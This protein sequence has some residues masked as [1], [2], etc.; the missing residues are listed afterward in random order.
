MTDGRLSWIW[1]SLLASLCGTLAHGA[2]M[3]LKRRAGWLPGFDPAAALQAAMLDLLPPAIPSGLA[4]WLVSQLNGATIIGLLFG[5]FFH[6]VPGRGGLAKGF[7]LGMAA[8]LL[9]GAALFPALGL[10]P[11]AASLGLG[12]WPALFALAMI[13]AY[14]L[15]LGLVYAALARD[16]KP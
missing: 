6:R 15:V 13:Q 11:F 3:E 1:K 16:D 9:L 14:S 7:V 12:A 4:P 2:L 8:W 5:R 10:G